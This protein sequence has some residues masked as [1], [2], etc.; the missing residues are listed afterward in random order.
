MPHPK[1]SLAAGKISVFGELTR[2]GYLPKRELK[3]NYVACRA[4]SR[5]GVA[6][7]VVLKKRVVR[8]EIGAQCVQDDGRV[9]EV[10]FLDLRRIK[11]YCGRDAECEHHR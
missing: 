7:I 1:P 2:L 3:R 4:T 11:Y 9:Q 10:T 5:C 6:G 8:R